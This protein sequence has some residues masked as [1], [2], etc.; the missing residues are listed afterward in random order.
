MEERQA[1]L[2]SDF[3]LR[4]PR[5]AVESALHLR[6]SEFLPIHGQRFPTSLLLYPLF[7]SHPTRSKGLL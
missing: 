2:A 3:L 4:A 1:D 7:L 5:I 6:D